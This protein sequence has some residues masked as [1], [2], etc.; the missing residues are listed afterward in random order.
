MYRIK[1]PLSILTLLIFFI[2]CQSSP[3]QSQKMDKSNTVTSPY[4]I[5]PNDILHIFVWKEP[6][7]TQDVVVMPDG[8]ISFPLIGEILAQGKTITQLKDIIAEKLKNYISAPEVTVIVRQSRSLSIYTIGKLINPGPYPFV[9]DMTVLQALSVAGGFTQ[10]AD[11]KN[12]LIIRR[13]GAKE[14]QIQFNYKEFISGQNPSQNI[15]LKPNDTI[16]VP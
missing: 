8:R 11:V 15:L 10:W 3:A 4:L 13:L 16:V 14:I 12:I 9:A 6:E 1:L 2:L 7:L 5:G